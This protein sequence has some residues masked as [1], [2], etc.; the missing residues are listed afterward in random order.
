MKQAKTTVWV[1][2]TLVRKDTLWD[3]SDAM[4]KKYAD[5]FKD[6]ETEQAVRPPRVFTADSP[7]NQA[8]PRE[9]AGTSAS[10]AVAPQRKKPGPKPG[11]RRTTPGVSTGGK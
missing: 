5:L 10:P 1:G 2:S 7:E 11:T 6:A 9:S 8:Q 3:D 4:V